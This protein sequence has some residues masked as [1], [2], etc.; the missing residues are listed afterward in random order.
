MGDA[1]MARGSADFRDEAGRVED[2]LREFVSR[3]H[4]LLETQERMRGLLAA[5]VSIAEELTLEAVLDRVV[6]AAQ[7]LVGARYAALGVLGPD[8]TD[9]SHFLTVGMDEETVKKIGPYPTGH[10]VLGLLIREPRPIRLHDLSTHPDSY[11]FP[12]EHPPMKTFLGVPVR[13]RDEVFGNLYLTEK[14]DGADFT[15]EDEELV[16]AL[17][18]AAGVAIE[19]ARLF[20]DT[21]RRQEWREASMELAG[22]LLGLEDLST[23]STRIAERT[24]SLSGSAFVA[25]AREGTAGRGHEWRTAVG[26]GAEAFGDLARAGA[27]VVAGK[28]AVSG[29]TLVLSG[30][31]VFGPGTPMAHVLVVPC[32]RPGQD[33]GAVIMARPEGRH[34]YSAVDIEMAP[35]FCSYASLALQVARQHRQR[36]ELL[37]FTDRDRIARDLHDVVIQRLFAAGLSLQ[38]LRRFV[39]QGADGERAAEKIDSITG[40]LDETIAALRTTIYSLNEARNGDSLSARLV[41]VVQEGMEELP[42]TPRVEL[43]GP[44]DT[45]VSVALAD[46]A[47]AVLTEGVSNVARHANADSLWVTARVADGEFEIV[48][49]D[50]G[51]GVGD[52]TR[53][54]GLKNVQERAA[55]L[56]G[57]FELGPAE[58][59]GTRLRWAV[60]L[61][62]G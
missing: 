1:P 57:S 52:T 13:V 47:L 38:G 25:I 56:G 41:R 12:G 21:A 4:E 15:A 35:V 14:A 43:L 18:A 45:A 5:V 51:R 23:G 28:V 53:R 22:E 6:T 24:L 34:E 16:V 17:A 61:G 3:A 26:P 30:P 19:N 59:G 44:I 62:A 7:E 11:G 37:V 9:L 27:L 46:Q 40:D 58:D 20:A 33:L 49:A 60:P 55:A 48:V 39:A 2:V 50:D 36:E 31:E 10:G 32:G 42:T 29:E 8:R 54:S